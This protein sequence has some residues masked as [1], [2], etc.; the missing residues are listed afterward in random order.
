M[1]FIPAALLLCLLAGCDQDVIDKPGTWSLKPAGLDANS[2]NLRAMVANPADLSAGTG[3]E[4]SNGTLATTPVQQLLAGRRARLP[5]VNASTVG[6]SGSSG[7]Q[8]SAGGTGASGV[9]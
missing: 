7:S 2:A 3:E 4:D 9:Q 8:P 5:S 1:R 6:A